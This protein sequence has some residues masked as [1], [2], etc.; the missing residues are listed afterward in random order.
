MMTT[1]KFLIIL[2]SVL[3]VAGVVGILTIMASRLYGNYLG[4]KR[5]FLV[6]LC[7][8]F[9]GLL[10][11]KLLSPKFNAPEVIAKNCDQSCPEITKSNAYV[12]GYSD[13]FNASTNF[14]RTWG[15]TGDRQQVDCAG[16]L[17]EGQAAVILIIGQS[18]AANT[19]PTRYKPRQQVYN[20]NFMDGK[21]YIARDPLLGAQG[22]GGSVWSR[23]GDMLVSDGQFDR[24]LL[25]PFSV[26]STTVQNW[27][28]GEL[29]ISMQSAI[30]DVHAKGIQLTHILWH[31]GEADR[32]TSYESYKSSFLQMADNIRAAGIK[33][34]L[35][36]SLGTLCWFGKNGL[37]NTRLG[38]LQ[39]D[40]VKIR[41]DVFLGPNTD[42]Y[43]RIR[44][45][46]DGCHFSDAT[47][48]SVAAEWVNILRTY[49]GEHGK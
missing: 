19:G 37:A 35:F 14:Y 13:G 12:A 20:Y 49:G 5:F 28:S 33:A 15:Y 41:D 39:I 16:I 46:H 32:T 25:V 45:R 40:L 30:R 18:N 34:P 23:L 17:S 43:D 27:A 1:I 8:G 48:Q 10:G 7:I 3:S 31:Q 26:G 11:A 4:L 29:S 36:I 2:S 24:V 22:Q 44:D 9:V 6:I 47:M 21:C 42:K 38:D